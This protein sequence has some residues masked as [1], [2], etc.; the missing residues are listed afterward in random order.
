MHVEKPHH[1]T[2]RHASLNPAS[3]GERFK[4]W[5]TKHLWAIILIIAATIIAGVFVFA[6]Y[7]IKLDSSEIPAPKKEKPTVYYSPLTGERVADE[8][9][10]KLPVTGVMIENSPEA[11]PQSGLKGAGVVYEAAAEGGITRFLALYQGAN[12]SH[13]GPVRSLRI[14]YLGWAAPYQASIAHVGGSGNAL[15]TVRSGKYRDID[16]FYNGN[17]YWRA[18]DRRAPHNVYTSTEKLNALNSTKGFKESVFTSFSRT[19]EKPAETATAAAITVNFSSSAYSTSYAYDKA[20][21]SYIR[22]LAGIGHTDREGGQIAPKVLVVLEAQTERRAGPD[23]YDDL[24]TTG[25][26]KATVFQNG[27]VA[28]A[29]WKRDNFDAPLKLVAN[30]G[31]DIA[32]NRGQTWVA[33]YTPRRGSLAWQ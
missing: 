25:S 30:D 21:N 5:F 15:S 33:A 10:T 27:T 29:T 31:K 20:S 9:A 14:Y 12:L 32:L 17:S 26:G 19:D 13:I 11:R 4:K 7:S 16:Q 1:N 18:T 22:S 24:I 3:R 23:G 2:P 8:A 28:E 6:L